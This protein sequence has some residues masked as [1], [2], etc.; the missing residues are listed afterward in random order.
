MPTNMIMRDSLLAAGWL[1]IIIILIILI[2]TLSSSCEL[3]TCRTSL[4][5]SEQS[6]LRLAKACKHVFLSSSGNGAVR[7]HP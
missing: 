5:F 2:L 1:I 3:G 6:M 7:Q 4:V